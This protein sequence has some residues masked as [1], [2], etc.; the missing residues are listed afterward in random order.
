MSKR[1]SVQNRLASRLEVLTTDQIETIHVATLDVLQNTGVQVRSAPAREILKDAGAEVDPEKHIVKFPPHL[2]EESVKKCPPRLTIYGRNPKLYCQFEDDWIN[3]GISGGPPHV[4]DLEGERRLATFKDVA[5]HC[6]LADALEN[7]HVGGCDII[8]TAEEVALPPRLAQLESTFIRVK[9]TEKPS[10]IMPIG[11]IPEDILEFCSIIRGGMDELRKKPMGWAW[12]NPLSPLIHDERLTDQ[13]IAYSRHGLPV[14]FASAVMAGMSGPVTLAGVLVQQNAEI[15][16][17]IVIA[18]MAADPKYRPPVIYGCAS[19]ATDLRIGQPALGGPEAALLNIA[20]AQI[21]KH[22]RLPCRGSGGSTDSKIPD[23][24]AGYESAI[25][26]LSAALIGVNYVYNAAGGLEPGLLA[27]SAEKLIMDNDSL[28]YLTRILSGITVEEDTLGVNLINQVGPGGNYLKVK[29]TRQFFRQE[30]FFPEI[31]DRQG[32][33]AWKEAG[34]KTTRQ[35][36]QER[37]R[38]LLDSYSP[39]PLEPELE[40]DLKEFIQKIRAETT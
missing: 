23:G 31:F 3:F 37:A 40:K 15:L 39:E 14:H 22:Y 2:V 34:G 29:H 10:I 5:E 11:S 24:Q 33:D 28:G 12:S 4:L 21:A 36:A 38:E 1:L 6:R 17:G 7:I 32:Y 13:V 27:C 18:Q 19:D 8:G 26:S 35:L 16:S 30:I 25:G 20:S 9:H